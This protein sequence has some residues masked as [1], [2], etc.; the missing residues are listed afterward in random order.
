MSNYQ[1]CSDASSTKRFTALAKTSLQ[2]LTCCPP[3]DRPVNS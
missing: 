1:T 2:L 3:R